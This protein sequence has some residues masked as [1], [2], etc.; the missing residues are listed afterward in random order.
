M[1]DHRQIL[2]HILSE[3]PPEIIRKPCFNEV[4][5]IDLFW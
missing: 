4:T 2:L 5:E 1:K 3:I